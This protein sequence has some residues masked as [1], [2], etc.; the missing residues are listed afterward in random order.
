[1]PGSASIGVPSGRGRQDMSRYISHYTLRID[2]KGRVSIPASF[3]A[4]LTR[5]GFDGLCIHPA[6][7]HPALEAGGHALLGEIDTLLSTLPPGSP[8]RD[9]IATALFGTTEILKVDPEGRIVL[10]ESAKAHAGITDAVTFA[11][12]GHK[13]QIW[14]PGRFGAHLQAARTAVRDLRRASD[15]PS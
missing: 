1:M 11:G 14:E 15:R 9:R 3:R 2:A 10:G 12:L 7:D 5:D 6:L 13:F 4:V 8:E